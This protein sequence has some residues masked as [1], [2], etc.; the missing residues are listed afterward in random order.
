MSGFRLE[1][2][3]GG[4]CVSLPKGET[5]IGRGPFLTISDKR[6]SRSH[7][8]LEVVDGKLRIKPV[9]VNPCFYQG[10]GGNTFIPLEKDKWHWLHSGDCFSLLPDKYTFK[11]IADTSTEE[12]TERNVHITNKTSE[13]ADNPSCSLDTT[14]TR[15]EEPSCSAW[16]AK[17]PYPNPASDAQGEKTKSLLNSQL[18]SADNKISSEMAS[19]VQR[20]RVLPDW[21]LHD[22][23]EIKSLSSPTSKAGKKKRIGREKTIT[24]SNADRSISSNKCL[25]P[26]SIK[27][28]QEEAC[29]TKKG[30]LE[31]QVSPG[32]LCTGLLT[33]TPSE[34]SNDD[35]KNNCLD[36]ES[37]QNIKEVTNR[38]SENRQSN[39]TSVKQIKASTSKTSHNDDLSLS[40]E[41]DESS[42]KANFNGGHEAVN[43]RTPCMYGENCYRKNPAHFEE[44]CHP[45][46]R[47]YDNTEKGSQDDSDERPEC[48]Y[49]TDCYRKNPQHKLE[50]KHTKPPGKGGRRLR[51]R[52]AKKGKSVLDDDSDNDGDPNEYDLEDSFLDDDE[53]EDFDNTDEDSDWMPDSEEK[54]T[55]DMKLLVKEAKKFVKGKH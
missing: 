31:S 54:D 30:T 48:P 13:I 1:A 18:F 33:K 12:S 36:V 51:K 4:E 35:D 38:Y 15:D 17:K 28:P 21:M 6:V 52:P 47:D 5:M 19:F 39:S 24:T 41:E 55:E 14:K 22:D 20:K 49:G 46:D 8:L 32:T 45:G 16:G 7:A 11:V 3:G 42:E 40:P 29:V 9:H 27:E 44:F 10:P 2:V 43:R 23:L 50:Y 34:K 37:N 25:A 53:E 26:S